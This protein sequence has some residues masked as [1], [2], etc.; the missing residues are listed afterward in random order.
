MSIYQMLYVSGTAKAMSKADI[1][2]ILTASRRNNAELDITGMLLHGDGVFIQIL[3]G[4][5]RKVRL[6]ADRIK[7]DPRHR[8]FMVLFEM[9]GEQRAFADWQMGFYRLDPSLEADGA[10]FA[11]SRAALEDR[12]SKSDGGMMFETVLAFGREFVTA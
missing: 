10:V 5:E 7:R 6:L 2:Q 4:D 9:Q 11:T 8:N 12:I 3:E 1:R